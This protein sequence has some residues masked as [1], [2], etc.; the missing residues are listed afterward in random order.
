MPPSGI[1]FLHPR[2]EVQRDIEERDD[3]ELDQ[4]ACWTAQTRR[5]NL[6]GALLHRCLLGLTA[7][8]QELK[9]DILAAL[10]PDLDEPRESA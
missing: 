1:T 2:Y 9:L 7:D 6:Y 3:E 5:A 8:H 4:Q 10:R